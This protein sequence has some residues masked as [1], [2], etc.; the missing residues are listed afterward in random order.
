VIFLSLL[1]VDWCG[2]RVTNREYLGCH[3][4]ICSSDGPNSLNGSVKSEEDPMKMKII[5]IKKTFCID[6]SLK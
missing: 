3:I 6:T 1:A 2:Q 4:F 5:L